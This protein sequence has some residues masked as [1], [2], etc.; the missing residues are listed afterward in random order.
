MGIME[1]LPNLGSIFTDSTHPMIA[2]LSTTAGTGGITISTKRQILNGI[3]T[4]T[5]LTNAAIKIITSLIFLTD[6]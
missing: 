1:W 5:K 3:T 2:R 6:T 4:T